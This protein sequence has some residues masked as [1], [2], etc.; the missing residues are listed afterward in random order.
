M[1]SFLLLLLVSG[2]A[3]ANDAAIVQCRNL[4][5]AG[6]RLACYDAIAVAAKPV[7]RAAQE[8]AFGLQ[9]KPVEPA[10]QEQA[11]GLQPKPVELTSFESTIPGQFNGWVPKQQITL[12]NGQVWRIAD[13]SDSDVSGKDLKVKV[14]RNMF[15]TT[16]LVVEGTNK[17]PKIR[18]VK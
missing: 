15:G 7:T 4:Q 18:R 14:E 1:K 12:A 13:D 10:R 8:Q 2:T 6:A 17:S 16:F 11:F 3:F 5:E 9:P